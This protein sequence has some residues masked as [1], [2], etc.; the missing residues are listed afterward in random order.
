MATIKFITRAKTGNVS[1]YLKLRNGNQTIV[2]KTGLN[3]DAKTWQNTT[4]LKG[5]DTVEIKNLKTTLRN[6]E[7]HIFD[8]L[9]KLS[10]EGKP[11]SSLSI[12]HEI[13]V[14]FKRTSQ[15]NDIIINFIDSIIKTAKNRP[16]KR[17]GIGLSKHAINYY[18]LLKQNIQD[19]QGHHNYKINE[20]DKRLFDKFSNYLLNKGYAPTTRALILSTLKTVHKEAKKSGLNVSNS[21]DL[22]EIK[23]PTPYDNK[24]M[25]VIVLSADEL[26][27]IENLAITSVSLKNARKWLILGCYVGQRVSDLLQ[28]TKKDF[29][30]TKD[31]LIIKIKQSK[32]NKTIIIPALPKVKAMYDNDNLPYPISRF[33]FSMQLKELGKLA[34]ITTPTVGRIRGKNKSV[35]KTRPKYMYLA[36]H[37]CRRTFAMLHYGKI[38][39][40]L[41]MRVTG[42]SQESTFLKYINKTDNSH[43]N[44]FSDFYKQQAALKDG[45]LKVV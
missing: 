19:F 10:T 18:K 27:T 9:N 20:L 17:G 31:G 37:I 4:A 43:V 11:I 36:S 13:S 33:Y 12:E 23:K 44:V 1:L 28:I 40:P 16:N 5:S 45:N 8:V 34:N 35:V 29:Y 38:P 30:H 26:Q 25:D 7:S 21:V 42:H 3:V 32:T 6:L 24:N 14:F 15:D 41:I 39:T 2:R 22:V